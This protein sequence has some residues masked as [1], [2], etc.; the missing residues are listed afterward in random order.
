MSESGDGKRMNGH[1]PVGL[2]HL[3]HPAL[4][5]ARL[6]ALDELSFSLDQVAMSIVRV[7][8]KTPATALTAQ[9][10][11]TNRESSGV[12]LGD[13]L[14]LTI[15]YVLL[16][17]D[18]V[19]LTTA[20]DRRVS[21]DIVGYDY[22]SGLGLLRSPTAA[23][24]P[25]LPRGDSS[26]LAERSAVIAAG[27]GGRDAVVSAIMVSR[28]EFAGYW[29][30]MLDEALFTSPPHPA[31]SGAALLDLDGKFVGLGSLFVNDSLPGANALPG[32]MFIPSA[33]LGE[34]LPTLTGVRAAR[35]PRPWLGLF[36]A[37][38]MGHLIVTGVMPGAPADKVGVTVG[39]IIVRVAGDR[40][41]ALRDLYRTIW[42]L[43][44]AG[45]DVPIT[46]VRDGNSRQTVIPSIDRRSFFRRP[47]LH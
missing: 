34:V 3:L 10:L 18:Q 33:L 22:E 40:V 6:A 46:L 2:L 4:K 44:A 14:V 8:T 35:P 24:L 23:Q 26:A 20:D 12:V 43:G 32:N 9:M 39:D 21:A 17:A 27:F 45:V 1:R 37:E 16:E 7:Q 41:R 31:W 25:S 11:G 5:S 30:Y 15:G 42:A 19:T 29:E 28:R 13:G 36:T 47:G 38:T